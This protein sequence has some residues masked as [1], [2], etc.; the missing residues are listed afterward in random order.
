MFEPYVAYASPLINI[1]DWFNWVSFAIDVLNIGL[2]VVDDNWSASIAQETLS[3]IA[4][5]LDT[6]T[7]ASNDVKSVARKLE[8]VTG[9]DIDNGGKS[10]NTVYGITRRKNYDYDIQCTDC[11]GGYNYVDGQQVTCETCHGVGSLIP[12][13]V[14]Y[15]AT[16]ECNRR[17]A[18][19][20]NYLVETQSDWTEV[21]D[22]NSGG[23]SLY[24]GG[25]DGDTPGDS[26]AGYGGSVDDAGFHRY[27]S[28]AEYPF[29]DGTSPSAG[30][31]AATN[32]SVGSDGKGGAT[33]TSDG[34]LVWSEGDKSASFAM[35]PYSYDLLNDW[36][37]SQNL[38]NVY[39]KIFK[40]N[41]GVYV[42]VSDGEIRFRAVAQDGYVAENTLGKDQH[43]YRWRSTDGNLY[44][45]G[46]S[47]LFSCF[48]LYEFRSLTVAAGNATTRNFGFMQPFWVSEE[49]N[50]LDGSGGDDSGG[51]VINNNFYNNTYET[52]YTINNT[53]PTTNNTTY[54]N[55]T[56]NYDVTNTTNSYNYDQS[57]NQVTSFDLDLSPVTM[58]LDA[59]NQMVGQI[60]TDLDSIGIDIAQIGLDLRTLGEWLFDAF[61]V[62]L[63]VMDDVIS[64]MDREYY[65]LGEIWDAI[66]DI[67]HG[68]SGGA[69]SADLSG[70]EGALSDILDGMSDL[71][72]STADLVDL[73]DL[74]DGVSDLLEAVEGLELPAAADLSTLEGLVSDVYGDT[75]DIGNAIG[76]W[77]T[78]QEDWWDGLTEQ[79][80]GIG[81]TLDDALAD[82]DSILSLMRSDRWVRRPYVRPTGPSGDFVI[83]SDDLGV[84]ALRDAI[85][86]LM[87]KFPF[88]TI[89][90]LALILT[91]LTRPAV[92]PVF[93]L[94]ILNPV[95]PSEPYLVHV[96]LSAWDTVASI[97]RV[98]ILLWVISKVS[99]S[100][101]KLWTRED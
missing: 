63:S 74:E 56:H 79:L 20:I 22:Q 37:E 29:R 11:M 39:A 50:F 40:G 78:A 2:D 12:D 84:D 85:T 42:I 35:D 53:W 47:L 27:G 1:K 51:D 97:G 86:E 15:S 57:T 52:D 81:D 100:T 13:K 24:G 75:T 8:E 18:A 32:F 10:V 9:Y 58:R 44:R 25:S 31:K 71:D 68:G 69:P 55:T 16:Y 6:R 7:F 70:I 96:D 23:G 67:D 45:V 34:T 33:G 90:N 99:R 89:N 73:T 54:N 36:I 4:S 72:R 19:W 95:T 83:L 5:E 21:D 98:G 101:V 46:E 38:E 76:S 43:F 66:L 59:L 65:R 28:I 80:Y 26:S 60:G 92:T 77:W 93:D 49:D 3:E 41:F 87:T 62:H 88:S 91:A 82:L 94:P 48:G 17:L 61:A 14:P 64:R 30:I